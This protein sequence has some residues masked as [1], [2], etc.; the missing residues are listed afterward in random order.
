MWINQRLSN[1]AV[2][3]GCSHSDG[4]R[5]KETLIFGRIWLNQ[6]S[7]WAMPMSLG[8]IRSERMQHCHPNVYVNVEVILAYCVMYLYGLLFCSLKADS[9][10]IELRIW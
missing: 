2:R 5:S 9:L 3:F 6:R 8:M 1:I 4:S 7:I 10:T